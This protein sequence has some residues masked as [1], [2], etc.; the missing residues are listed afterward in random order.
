[1]LKN[2]H[3]HMVSPK[4]DRNTKK[5]VIF[6]MNFINFYPFGLAMCIYTLHMHILCKKWHLQLDRDLLEI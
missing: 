5:N 6:E 2:A 4:K 3:G 1:M